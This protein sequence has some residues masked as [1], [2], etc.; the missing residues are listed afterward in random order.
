MVNLRLGYANP[1]G[2]FI[3]IRL[4][5]NRS[6]SRTTI[7]CIIHATYELGIDATFWNN[8]AAKEE[9]VAVDVPVP[10]AAV[11]PVEPNGEAKS[12]QKPLPPPN[13]VSATWSF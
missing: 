9:A 11:A 8:E 5:Q 2:A 1:N 3:Q 12:A 6:S 13:N 7:T 10:S 4:R